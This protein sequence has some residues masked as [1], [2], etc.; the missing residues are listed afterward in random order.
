M[1]IASGKFKGQKLKS[2]KGWRIVESKVKEALGSLLGEQ[3]KGK[4][5]LD[6]F[7]GVGSIGLE[8]LSWGAKKVAFVDI[9]PKAAGIIR[10]NLD[11]LGLADFGQ[12]YLRDALSQIKYFRDKGIKFDIIF[13]D[14]P[15]HKGYLIKTLKTLSAYD[16]LKNSGLLVVLSSRREPVEKIEFTCL[17][18]RC[19]GDRIVRIYSHF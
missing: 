10:E 15:Y 7:A 17:F 9:N 4:E 6:I 11:I 1:H 5:I 14:P 19:Y 2:L 18:E 12:V 8:S 3:A 16:I 13:L